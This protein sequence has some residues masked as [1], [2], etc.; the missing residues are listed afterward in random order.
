MNGTVPVNKE[1]LTSTL[2]V[3]K[4]L[5]TGT[6]AVNNFYQKLNLDI[7]KIYS[8]SKEIAFILNQ[9]V[10]SLDDQITVYHEW[11]CKFCGKTMD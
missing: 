6:V 1:L 2:P 9:E 10:S 4:E 3:N 8:S 11:K 7:K 5:L